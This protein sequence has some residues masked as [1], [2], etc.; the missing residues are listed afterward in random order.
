MPKR[1]DKTYAYEYDQLSKD[2]F[3]DDQLYRKLTEFTLLGT[4]TARSDES[5]DPVTYNLNSRGFRGPELGSTELLVAGCSQTFGTGIQNDSDTWPAILAA[6]LGMSYANVAKPGAG[7][8][9]II[10]LIFAYIREYGVPKII[11][12]NLPSLYRFSL[13]IRVDINSYPYT[14]PGGEPHRV[15]KTTY[16]SY[17]KVIPFD[18][19][20]T[21]S[22]SEA[23]DVINWPT[24]SK[25]PYDITKVISYEAVLYMSMMSINHL[26]DYCKAAKIKLVLTTWYP[27]TDRFLSE[28]KA[29]TLDTATRYDNTLD[30][31]DYIVLEDLDLLLRSANLVTECHQD[32]PH[33]S[34]W[35]YALDKA[36][37]MGVHMHTHLA[38]MLH[39]KISER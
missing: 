17:S 26:I 1:D 14:G 25:R 11:C 22:G 16:P 12:V 36:R 21:P 10:N 38:E 5:G 15:E 9:T 29:K 7:N 24:Y 3:N 33:N 32:L 6:S 30:M 39:K 35:D 27:D 18:M 37:H 23:D 34:D 31:S 13:P 19:N 20:M 2:V 8:Q 28:K 4:S